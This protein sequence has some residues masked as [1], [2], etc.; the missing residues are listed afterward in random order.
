MESAKES[1]LAVNPMQAEALCAAG[2]SGTGVE[3][4]SESSSSKGRKGGIRSRKLEGT[5]ADRKDLVLVERTRHKHRNNSKKKQGCSI[6]GDY[7][8]A[9]SEPII[10]D[11]INI[12]F[13]FDIFLRQLVAHIIFFLAPFCIE[14]LMVQGF[15]NWKNLLGVQFNVLHALTVYVIIALYF[16]SDVNTSSSS[17]YP[18]TN[19]IGGIIVF[20]ILY[21]FQHKCLVAFKYAS[22]SRS[23]YCKIAS[24][25]DLTIGNAFMQQIQILTAWLWLEPNVVMFELGASAARIGARINKINF[26]VENP[27]NSSAALGQFR[28][29]NC[30]LRGHDVVDFTSPTAPEMHKRCDGNYSV[31]VDS[32]CLALLNTPLK[33]Q[34]IQFATASKCI[35]IFATLNTAIP[36]IMFVAFYP[37]NSVSK[38]KFMIAGALLMCTAWL[39]FMYSALFYQLLYASIADATRQTTMYSELSY[40]LRLTDLMMI[41]EL[42]VSTYHATKKSTPGSGDSRGFSSKMPVVSSAVA[43]IPPFAELPL[44]DISASKTD[45]GART[46]GKRE[47]YS[48]EAA[49]DGDNTVSSDLVNE[50]FESASVISTEEEVEA[51]SVIGEEPLADNDPARMPRL[52]MGSEQNIMAWTHARLA[53]QYF[54]IRFRSR[55][56]TAVGE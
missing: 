40:M 18:E 35:F 11:S 53:L 55:L 50:D 49:S 33:R 24:A 28:L 21:W 17:K 45:L 2:T 47:G 44:S 23:E 41:S 14:N 10:F 15:F 32:A 22:L 9:V 25:A 6:L 4:V 38:Q 26:V 20:P 39:N 36:F 34:Q 54:G 48:G 43:S 16:M 3:M 30:F 31:S 42:D 12:Q 8:E 46:T 52:W 27:E 56:E 13:H 7:V 29:W 19:A 51:S 37:F 1:A 5:R